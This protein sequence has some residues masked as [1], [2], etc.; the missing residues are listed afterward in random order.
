M[1][2]KLNFFLFRFVS[3]VL[4][5]ENLGHH[6]FVFVKICLKIATSHALD[7]SYGS[8]ILQQSDLCVHLSN[9]LIGFVIEVVLA[10]VNV[11]VQNVD[12]GD[13]FLEFQDVQSFIVL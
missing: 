5:L 9:V 12:S 13:I 8:R 10:D 6:F 4:D 1:A 3:F 7:L 11:G 2:S